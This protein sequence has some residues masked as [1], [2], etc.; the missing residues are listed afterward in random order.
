MLCLNNVRIIRNKKITPEDSN[1]FELQPLF[2]FGF[3]TRA[4]SSRKG[5]ANL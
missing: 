3:E 2:I 5:G 4:L 1:G